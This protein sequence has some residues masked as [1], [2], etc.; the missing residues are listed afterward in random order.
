[1]WNGEGGTRHGG[2]LKHGGVPLPGG[3]QVAFDSGPTPVLR[4]ATGADKVK[5]SAVNG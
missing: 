3:Q 5:C 1:L 2:V 4:G